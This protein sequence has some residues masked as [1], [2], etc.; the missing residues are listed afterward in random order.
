MPA[1]FSELAKLAKDL[2]ATGSALSTDVVRMTRDTGDRIQRRAQQDAPED[3]GALKS[4]IKI[5]R[6]RSTRHV[7]VTVT[8][9]SEYALFQEFGTTRHRA[10]PFMRPALMAEVDPFIEALERIVGDTLR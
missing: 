4:S 5:S 2:R 9:N 3:S 7:S 1:D 10:Q 8:A 6:S